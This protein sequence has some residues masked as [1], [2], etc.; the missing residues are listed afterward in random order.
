MSPSKKDIAARIAKLREKLDHHNYRYYVLDDPEVDDAV[1]DA[2]FRELAA[3]EAEHPEFGDANSP[4]RRVGGAPAEGFSSREHRQRMYSLDN[5]MDEEEFAAFLEKIRRKDAEADLTFWIDPKFD[6]LAMEVIYEKGRFM[7]ALTRGDGVAGEDV[8]QN[9][10]TVKNLP[11][12]LAPHA[13]RSGL[14]VPALLEVRGE[15]I[16]TR[17]EFFELNERQRQTGDKVFANPRNAAAGSLRQLDPAVTATRPLRFFAYGV[18]TLEWSGKGPGWTTQ[19]DVMGGVAA[20]GFQVSDLGKTGTPDEVVAFYHDLGKR[21]GDLPFEIDGAVAKL[22]VL[23]LQESLGFTDRA[24]RWAVAL[25]FPAHQAETTLKDIQ[26]QVGRSGV[27]TPVA[28]LEPV[29]L[30]GVTVSRATLHNE[31]EIRA[32]DLRPGCRVVVQRAGDVIPEVVRAVEDET[33]AALPPYIFPENCPACGSEAVREEGEAAWR[34][35]NL[36]CP[37]VLAQRIIFFVS[38]AGLDIQG[39]GKKWI[40][41]LATKGLA[42]GG[43]IKSPADLFRIREE[44]LLGLEGMGEKSASNF[45]NAFQ[46]AKEKA[47]LAKLVS[48]LGIRHVGARTAKTLAAHFTDL[49]ALGGADEEDLTALPDIG[50][51]VSSSIREFFDN[52]KNLELLAEFK[53]LGLWPREEIRNTPEAEAPLSGKRF[54]FTGALP[55]MSREEAQALVEKAGG[56]AVSSVSKKL[57]YLVAGEAPGSKLDKARSMG[58]AVIGFEE[59]LRLARPRKAARSVQGSLLSQ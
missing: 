1:Y 14:P 30:A 2:F 27:L 36:S 20:L 33:H 8:T 54:L 34:C 52:D 3:L 13:R 25:K 21:R 43:K 31:D 4:T 19:E 57:D 6:G 48:A 38:K 12:D 5:A 41:H 53:K 47:T 29:S 10:R 44:D 26:V 37:A 22:N 32:K 56:R 58:V 42:T 45:V 49:D 16:L 17:Q 35:V 51:E 50:P 28:N 23:A 7:S 18:G 24:P 15:V 55:G 59:F 46:E 40:E 11:M 9:M 39:V